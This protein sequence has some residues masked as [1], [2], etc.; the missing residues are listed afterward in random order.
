MDNQLKQALLE[1]FKY[2]DEKVPKNYG[3][4][5]PLKQFNDEVDEGHHASFM[6]RGWL[7]R[8]DKFIEGSE[9]WVSTEVIA[10]EDLRVTLWDAAEVLDDLYVFWVSETDLI[11]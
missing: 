7:V 4:L 9:R 10:F 8:N 3:T 6:G 11:S 2:S 5:I 1:R